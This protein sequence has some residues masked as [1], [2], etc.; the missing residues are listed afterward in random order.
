M[1]AVG[2][3]TRTHHNG[4]HFCAFGRTACI[5]AIKW[6]LSAFNHWTI[7]T[8]KRLRRKY[9]EI[10]YASSTFWMLV[11]GDSLT[12]NREKIIAMRNFTM[13]YRATA[14]VSRIYPSP[15][16]DFSGTITA[17][18]SCRAR[19]IVINLFQTDAMCITKVF[20]YSS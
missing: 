14:N 1:Q 7:Q 5:L 10:D 9:D 20:A 12:G 19:C 16:L 3:A 4:A 6:N 17:I 15:R 18:S 8:E 11:R 2:P 13:K